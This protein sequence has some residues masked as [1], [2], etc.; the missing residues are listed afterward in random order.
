ML[1]CGGGGGVWGRSSGVGGGAVV[2]GG[3][4]APGM[5]VVC[6]PWV[7]WGCRVRMSAIWPGRRCGGWCAR[8]R[9]NIPAGS[10][11]SIPT[12][13]TAGCRRRCWPRGS[14]SWWCVPGW[15]M[16]PG[17]PRWRR[18]A[19]LALPASESVWRLASPVVGHVGGS[20]GGGFPQAEAPLAAGQV[21]VA[22][23]A[24]GVNFRDVLVALGM[25]PDGAA[26]WA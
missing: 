8:R 7:R 23:G 17:W 18:G 20:G 9:P 4:D 2:A 11:W 14:L 10:C 3:H 26:V 13:S 24:V 1:W 21:R 25:Y 15:C 22:V 5:L 6:D 19:V 12:G 16:P